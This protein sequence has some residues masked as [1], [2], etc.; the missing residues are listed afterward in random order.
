MTCEG[1]VAQLTLFTPE[2]YLSMKVPSWLLSG[3]LAL[4]RMR[5]KQLALEKSSCSCE[6]ARDVTK[7]G[8]LN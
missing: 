3:A 2:E 1:R 6:S 8:I 4:G 5:I 7:R